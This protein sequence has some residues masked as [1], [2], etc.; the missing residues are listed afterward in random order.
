MIMHKRKT[1]TGMLI[2]LTMI[3]F[4]QSREVFSVETVTVFAAA[5]TTD[6]LTKVGDL[7]L[8]KGM[9]KVIFS[10]ASSSILAKQIERGALAQVF[11]SADSDWMDTT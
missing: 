10:F 1:I 6:A 11:L 5:S 8:Q 4:Q 9:G 2:A 7:F 3:C